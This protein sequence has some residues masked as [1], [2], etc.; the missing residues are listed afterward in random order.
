MSLHDLKKNKGFEVD[1]MKA[2]QQD[3]DILETK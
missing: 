1:K 2:R 3:I